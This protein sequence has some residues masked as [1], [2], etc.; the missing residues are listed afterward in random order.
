MDISL[1]CPALAA[2]VPTLPELLVELNRRDWNHY[3]FSATVESCGPD[4]LLLTSLTHAY[5]EQKKTGRGTVDYQLRLDFKAGPEAVY[6]FVQTKDSRSLTE[7]K[8]LLTADNLTF[9]PTR[10]FL[11]ASPLTQALAVAHKKVLDTQL[12]N[13]YT[14]LELTLKKLPQPY[15]LFVPSRDGRQPLELRPEV[16]ERF[17]FETHKYPV[18]GTRLHLSSPEWQFGFHQPEEA[19]GHLDDL[20][21]V[22]RSRQTVSLL[23]YELWYSLGIFRCPWSAHR[24]NGNLDAALVPYNWSR[25]SRPGYVVLARP[26][27]FVEY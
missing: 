27:S 5:T 21:V 15:T 2:C 22:P 19:W 10:N 14:D 4:S 24:Q 9:E 3:Q 7:C 25:F 17:G 8:H 16:G 23:R 11:T 12:R 1:P 13:T 20:F 26:F 18:L 6:S